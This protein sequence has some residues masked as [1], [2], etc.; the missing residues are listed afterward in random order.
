MTCSRPI[1]AA[2]LAGFLAFA[3]CLL[4]S[5]HVINQARADRYFLLQHCT[6]R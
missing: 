5:T 1:S 3:F 2:L 6:F 4:Y